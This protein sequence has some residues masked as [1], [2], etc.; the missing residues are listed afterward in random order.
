[1]Q[2]V[3]FRDELNRRALP[4]AIKVRGGRLVAMLWAVLA[5]GVLCAFTAAPARATSRG[6]TAT[7]STTNARRPVSDTSPIAARN[8]ASASNAHRTA[9]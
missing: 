3:R 5:F 6:M 8:T 9:T 4:D 7:R 2:R 1:M